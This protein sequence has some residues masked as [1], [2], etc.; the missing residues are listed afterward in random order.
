M[1]RSKVKSIRRVREI[2]GYISSAQPRLSKYGVW[3]V[4]V[5]L[6]PGVW[7][8]PDSSVDPCPVGLRVNTWILT[9]YR[10]IRWVSFLSLS[11][12]KYRFLSRLSLCLILFKLH[13]YIAYSER[14]FGYPVERFHQDMFFHC[15]YIRVFM[16]CTVRL[17]QRVCGKR[18]RNTAGISLERCGEKKTRKKR[19]LMRVCLNAGR[20]ERE[21]QTRRLSTTT[22]VHAIVLYIY[23]YIYIYIY[24]NTL[25][26][27]ETW[28]FLKYITKKKQVKRTI[29]WKILWSIRKNF[30]NKLIDVWADKATKFWE[31]WLCTWY[32]ERAYIEDGEDSWYN[33]LVACIYEYIK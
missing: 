19:K 32:Y 10:R 28:S 1:R 26:G 25:G 31:T 18:E 11:I 22:R 6:S 30:G 12:N 23:I 24:M 3:C 21:R 7:V 16:C 17:R 15:S 4:R 14:V 20:K 13:I 33:K 29:E 8:E 27:A 5:V 2:G 9:S